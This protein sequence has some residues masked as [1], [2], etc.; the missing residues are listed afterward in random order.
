VCVCVRVCV[1]V[2]V[3]VCVILGWLKVPVTTRARSNAMRAPHKTAY[4][5]RV[6]N[7]NCKFVGHPPHHAHTYT[8][9]S[10]VLHGDSYGYN[11]TR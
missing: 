1:W 5:N 7:A 11:R 4:P 8:H 3:C 10:C 6:K 2:C 9:A